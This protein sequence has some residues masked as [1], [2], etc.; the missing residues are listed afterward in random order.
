MSWVEVHPDSGFPLQNLPYGVFKAVNDHACRIG[1]AI[2][3]HV[4]SLPELVQAGLL[5]FP[6]LSKPTLNEFM[7]LGPEQ[8]SNA[9][10]T[11]QKLLAKDTPTLRDNTELRRRALLR[12]DQV[13][14]QMPCEIGDYTDFYSSRQHATNV[15]IMFRGPD[16]ALQPN[17]LHMPIGYHGRAS[18]VVVSG[19]NLHRPCGQLRPADDKPP[20]HGPCQQLD[21]ELEMAFFVGPGSRLGE[22]LS[23]ADAHSHIF[24]L[25]LMNDWSA[26]DV[27]K[28]EYVP[29]GPFNGKNFGTSISPWIVT[30]EALRPFQVEPEPQT[31]PPLPYIQDPHNV[32][33]DINL[34]VSITPD[35]PSASEVIV[36]RTNARHLYWSFA[37][38]LAHHTST[39]CNVRPGD[40]MGSGTISGS[41]PGSFGSMLEISWKGTKPVTM[42][43]G[44]QRCFLQDGDTVRM[45]G[46]C[47]SSKVPY[48]IGF[49][50][51]VGKVLPA[52]KKV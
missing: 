50:D 7:S 24:G 22:P 14:M 10:R 47:G 31:P 6:S 15:G 13:A 28:W 3:D 35:G 8:W 11:I 51:V 42:K 46:I 32:A 39:G 29:L 26:R 17:W 2:G 40:L 34:E 18:S 4:L 41:E 21:F 45:T 36:S 52:F 44:T 43:D 27:Q 9:R 49:G 16:N 19:T 48:K 23:I 12:R 20:V 37:Q 30:M 33:Y 25:V 38:Q 1:V 5:P